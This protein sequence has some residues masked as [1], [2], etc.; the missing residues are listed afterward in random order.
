MIEIACLIVVG[1][2]TYMVATDGIWPAAQTFLCTLLAGLI[3]MNF[4]EPLAIQLK[5]FLPDIYCDFVA[6]VGLFIALV[7]GLRMG[8]EQIAPSYIQIIPTVDSI[9]RWFFGAA[10]GYLTM[11]FLLTALHTAPLSRDFMGFQP[12]RANFFGDAPDRR[13]L[14]FVQYV[15]E[16]PFA[17]YVRSNVKGGFLPRIFDGY[18]EVVGDP[19]KP[20]SY[21]DA[22]GSD[23]PQ[24]V[25]PS[26]PIRYAARRD[27]YTTNQPLTPP[28]PPPPPP[29]ASTSAPKGPAGNPGF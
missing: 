3:A 23:V 29:P 7:F 22:S 1:V 25:W 18:I 20:Y 6:L 8:G 11:A 17:T 15:S 24:I 16:K 10:T 14:G 13:W 2:V 12:E 27:R 21:R 9:G 19:A 26:F 4:F 28:P 5:A